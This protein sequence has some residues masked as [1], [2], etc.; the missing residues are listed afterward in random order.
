MLILFWS[1]QTWPVNLEVATKRVLHQQAKYLDSFSAMSHMEVY[2]YSYLW[3]CGYFWSPWVSFIKTYE[4]WGSQNL[5][6]GL[7]SHEVMTYLSVFNQLLTQWIVAILSKGCKSDNFESYNSLKLSFTNIWGF[8][9]NFVNC[10]FFLESNSLDILALCETNFDDSSDY[11]N[12]SVGYL[13]LIQKDSINHMYG[14]AAYVKEG[15]P[16][17]WDLSLDNSAES[18]LCFWLA[19]LHS[20]SYFF[21]L[22]Q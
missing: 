11:G 22:Y 8:L 18:Y 2:L 14:L 9:S 7:V 21:L 20:V 15:L 13:P 19:L 1:S 6:Q 5:L 4:F 16:F 10:E 17:P 12:F 3:W